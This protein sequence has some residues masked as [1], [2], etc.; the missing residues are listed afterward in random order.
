MQ[1]KELSLSS[2]AAGR[3]MKDGTGT[4]DRRTVTY[5]RECEHM[6][7]TEKQHIV[8]DIVRHIKTTRNRILFTRIT[9]Q[10]PQD[11][12]NRLNRTTEAK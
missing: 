7:E 2:R 4:I 9:G 8:R 12:S 5:P 3:A 1:E 6:S 10:S 11:S